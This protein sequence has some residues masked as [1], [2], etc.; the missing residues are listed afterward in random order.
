MTGRA[1]VFSDDRIV[2]LLQSRFVAV[3]DNCSYTQRQ[4]DAKGEF[5]R[6]IAEQGHYAGRTNPTATRQ[7][8]YA[9]TADG[10]LLASVNTTNADRLLS[11]L[12]EALAAW[13]A[14]ERVDTDAPGAYAADPRYARTFPEGG[15]ILRETMRDLPRSGDPE[16]STWQHNFDYMWLTADEAEGL[17]PLDTAVGSQFEAP[18]AVVTRLARFHMVDHVR[19]EAPSWRAEDVEDA[20]LMLRVESAE[21]ARVSMSVAGHVRVRRGPTE[22]ENPFS[23]FRVD[24]ER[25]VDV[26]GVVEVNPGAR[27]VTELRVVATGVRWGATTYN[28]RSKDLGPAP[29]GFAFELIPD[30]PE[31]R[32]PP[33]FV[34]GSY[35]SK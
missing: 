29:I 22:E 17:I 15:L 20:R 8:L 30:T 13:D 25:G 26:D 35:F 16:A 10:D 23:G 11:V 24:T 18:P 2:R 12:E 19:G 27:V 5:F 3:T 21:G 1:S 33:K 7:G 31:N 4:D 6:H 9:C 28:G 34:P 32:T 14:R